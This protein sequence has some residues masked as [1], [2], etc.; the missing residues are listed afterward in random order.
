M[1]D[2]DARIA[3]LPE[4]PQ[5]TDFFRPNLLDYDNANAR[6]HCSRAEYA[7]AVA[8]LY[9][10]FQRERYVKGCKRCRGTGEI[11]SG[12]TSAGRGMG[13]QIVSSFT[14][15]ACADARKLLEATKP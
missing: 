2:L 13:G 5:S 9:R 8:A 10:D 14:C 6:Y 11:T 15:P 3:A 12:S 1:I 4:R 7:E